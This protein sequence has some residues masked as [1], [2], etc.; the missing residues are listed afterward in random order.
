MEWIKTDERLPT[1]AIDIIIHYSYIKSWAWPQTYY[2]TTI[3]NR[4][5]L[6]NGNRVY[7]TIEGKTIEPNRVICWLEIPRP[8]ME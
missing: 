3:A 2:K 6:E 7:K 4:V 8:P 1:D 5:Y